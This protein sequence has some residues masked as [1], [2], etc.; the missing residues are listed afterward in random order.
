MK[1]FW[2]ITASAMAVVSPGLVFAGNAAGFNRVISAIAM[3]YHAHAIRIPFLGLA[4]FVAGKPTDGG[5]NGMRAARFEHFPPD[6]DSDG[7]TRTVEES[8]GPDWERI[9]RD[10]S[11]K[12]GDQTL[13]FAHPQGNRMG[14]LVLD[15]DNH[16]LDV[17]QVSVDPDHLNETISQYCHQP[18]GG[19]HDLAESN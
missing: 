12:G 1:R 15:L 8:L 18:D 11:R 2:W 4:S 7:L 5:V 13:V 3:R 10:T 19:G 16:E 6:A 14:L 17:V 9:I